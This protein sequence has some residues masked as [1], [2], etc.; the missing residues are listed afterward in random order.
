MP[1]EETQPL[2]HSETTTITQSNHHLPLY[3]SELYQIGSLT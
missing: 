2:S 1:K 3:K